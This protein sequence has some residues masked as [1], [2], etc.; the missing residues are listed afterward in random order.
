MVVEVAAG[1]MEDMEGHRRIITMP[2]LDSLISTE[3]AAL[4][5]HRWEWGNS[6]DHLNWKSEW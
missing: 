4:M 6:K 5:E 1:S 2:L 3:E